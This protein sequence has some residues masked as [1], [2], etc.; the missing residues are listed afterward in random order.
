MASE[1]GVVNTDGDF[2]DYMFDMEKRALEDLGDEE[3]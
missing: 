2:F 1:E 3:A